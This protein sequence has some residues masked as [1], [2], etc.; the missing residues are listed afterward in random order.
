MNRYVRQKKQLKRY[1]WPSFKSEL[2]DLKIQNFRNIADLRKAIFETWTYKEMIAGGEMTAGIVKRWAKKFE[3]KGLRAQA[4]SRKIV[5]TEEKKRSRKTRITVK[6]QRGRKPVKPIVPRRADNNPFAYVVVSEGFG[7]I[8]NQ[9]VKPIMDMHHSYGKRKTEIKEY[10]RTIRM[11]KDFSIFIGRYIG[12]GILGR[13]FVNGQYEGMIVNIRFRWDGK[14]T[15]WK[16]FNFQTASNIIDT[17]NN[18]E[19]S[20]LR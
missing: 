10:L 5:V 12:G 11:R 17:W 15:N 6:K 9:V 13:K 3:Y 16:I 18:S 8:I 1:Y 14:S 2:R 19:I 4:R 7:D 20:T